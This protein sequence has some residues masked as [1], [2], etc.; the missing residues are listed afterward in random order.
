MPNLLFVGQRQGADFSR[1]HLIGVHSLP[2]IGCV[3]S[4]GKGSWLRWSFNLEGEREKAEPLEIKNN[5]P[6][7]AQPKVTKIWDVDQ[8]VRR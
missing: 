4:I 2:P 5:N 7:L 6:Y 8:I 1:D 3:L